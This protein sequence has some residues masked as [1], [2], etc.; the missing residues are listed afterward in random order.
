[1]KRNN[2]EIRKYF[3]IFILSLFYNFGN[4]F[5][6]EQYIKLKNYDIKLKATKNEL[7]RLN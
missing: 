3:W 4:K 2:K 6:T 7:N 5:S 1:M